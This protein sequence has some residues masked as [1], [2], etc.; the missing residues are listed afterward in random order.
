MRFSIS[1]SH[2]IC[3]KVLLIIAYSY[4]HRSENIES[5]DYRLDRMEKHQSTPCELQHSIHYTIL[6]NMDVGFCEE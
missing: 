1:I 4:V 6:H 5:N 2:Y 3:F